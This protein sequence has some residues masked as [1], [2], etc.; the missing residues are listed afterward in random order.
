MVSASPAVTCGA[1]STAP[2]SPAG[3]YILRWAAV[4]CFQRN[5]LVDPLSLPP[6]HCPLQLGPAIAGACRH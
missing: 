5:H 4:R 1:S 3:H 2:F 6:S